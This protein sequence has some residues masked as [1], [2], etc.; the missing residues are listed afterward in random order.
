MASLGWMGIAFP[1]EYGGSGGSFLDL[2]L[3]LEEMGYSACPGPFFST[4]VLG[5]LPIMTGGNEGQKN[6]FLPKIARGE[7]ILTLALTEPKAGFDASSVRTKAIRSEGGYLIS[8][9]KLFVPDADLAHFLLCVARTQEGREAEEGITLFLVEAGAQGI[10]CTRLETLAKDRQC[11]VVF[12]DVG[13]STDEILG[14][15]NRGWPL[16]R[17]TLQRAAVGRCAEMI[18]GAQRVMEMALAHARERV[19]FGRPIGGFQAIHGHFADMWVEICGSRNLLYKAAWMLSE[20]IPADKEVAMAKAKVGSACRR[21]TAL[22][23]Q[24]FGAIGFTMEH[25]MHLYYRR[26]MAG[27]L[28]FGDSEFHKECVARELG[29]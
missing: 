13:V 8:G 17:G 3:L 25:P 19:Q 14:V 4:V 18:G 22:G 21:V 12:R 24:I 28:S 1:E 26:A 15:E 2:V 6:E 20:G 29:L 5:G 10:E 7:L 9:T 16:V 27:E 23:H 11:E